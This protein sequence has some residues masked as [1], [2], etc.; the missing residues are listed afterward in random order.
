MLSG[1]PF[2]CSLNFFFQGSVA[3]EVETEQIVYDTSVTDL[4]KSK[5][6]SFVQMRGSIP[7]Y[8]SQDISKMVPKP[9]IQCKFSL[10]WHYPHPRHTEKMSILTL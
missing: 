5:I 4:H 7:V 3:N 1:V 8:W 2:T 6:A 10:K 9:V